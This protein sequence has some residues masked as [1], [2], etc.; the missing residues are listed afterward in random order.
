MRGVPSSS[1]AP[2]HAA[3]LRRLRALAPTP[4]TADPGRPAQP[5][6]PAPTTPPHLVPGARPAQAAPPDSTP[7]RP[8]SL[9]HL[10]AMLLASA[11]PSVPGWPCGPSAPPGPRGPQPSLSV[12][13]VPGPTPPAEAPSGRGWRRSGRLL[14]SRAEELPLAGRGGQNVTG[15]PGRAVAGPGAGPRGRVFALSGSGGVRRSPASRLARE[16]ARPEDPRASLCASP[17]EHLLPCGRRP[18]CPFS[19]RA[20]RGAARRR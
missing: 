14:K 19:C 15:A 17:L 11:P 18:A 3:P 16:G 4:G 9:P 2:T 20:L 7:G 1:R 12:S 5:H 6:T 8:R 13:R 10:R